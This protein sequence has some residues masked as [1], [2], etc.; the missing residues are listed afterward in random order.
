MGANYIFATTHKKGEG[1]KEQA[2][3]VTMKGQP[4][5]LSGGEVMIGQ[6]APDFEVVAPD[7]STVSF[8]SFLGKTCIISSVPSLDTPVCDIQTRR[9]N[10]EV[11]SLDQEVVLLTISMDL[12]FAQQRWCGAADATNVRALSDYRHASFGKAFGV[13]IEELRLLTRAVFVVDSKGVV[14]YR[15]IVA[16]ITH[17]PDYEAALNTIRQCLSQ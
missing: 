16:E 17:E 11:A 4:L 5:A 7:L 12:P 6:K 14:K 1:M 3:V 13:L 9:F 10:Q 2:S 8:S 15:E